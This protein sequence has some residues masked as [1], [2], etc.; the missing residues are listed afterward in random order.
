MQRRRCE[1][2]DHIGPGS[3]CPGLG[4]QGDIPDGA[5]AIGEELIADVGMFR[6]LSTQYLRAQVVG[7]AKDES[8]RRRSLRPQPGVSP[9]EK[10]DPLGGM[11]GL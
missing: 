7:D 2:R 4:A 8:A 3:P 5:V 9:V 11:N 1:R 6:G 10:R